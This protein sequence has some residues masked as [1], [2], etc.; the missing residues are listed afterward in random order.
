[1]VSMLLCED[2]YSLLRLYRLKAA[3][4]PAAKSRDT[5]SEHHDIIECILARDAEAAE[6]AMRLQVH[7]GRERMFAQVREQT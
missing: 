5:H 6:A 7:H 4:R 2:L 1:M 3:F